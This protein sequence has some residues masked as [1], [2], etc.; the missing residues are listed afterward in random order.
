MGVFTG[1]G[2]PTVVVVG[3]ELAVAAEEVAIEVAA[4][5]GATEV[6][7]AAADA[8]SFAFVSSASSSKRVLY[9]SGVVQTVSEDLAL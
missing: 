2:A 1:A 5:P 7:D 4:T 9:S 6:V 8:F 3:A